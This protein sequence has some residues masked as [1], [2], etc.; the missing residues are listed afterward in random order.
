MKW[1]LG[2]GPDVDKAAR[3]KGR[4]AWRRV[5]HASLFGLLVVILCTG[6]L[7]F[8]FPPGGQVTLSVG[9]VSPTDIR[10]PAQRTFVSDILTQ[11]ARA[12]AEA[13]VQDVYDPPEQRVAR[14]QIA[15]ARD[16]L[17]FIESVRHDTAASDEERAAYLKAIAD[18]PL[19]D[20]VVSKILKLSDAAWQQ[21][22]DE[23]LRVLGLV[24]REEIRQTWLE[25]KR[26]T[27]PARVSL[28]LDEA[29]TDVVV[30]LVR[31]LMRSNTFYNAEKTA[32]LRRQKADSVEPVGRTIEVGEVILR[33][34]DI[35]DE[36]DVEALEALGLREDELNW[37]EVLE[38][39]AFLLV[40]TITGWLYLGRTY[41]QIW[42]S[43]LQAALV[44][45]LL[46]LFT[47]L[48]KV[49]VAGHVA[50][51]YLFPLA[52]LSMLLASL[53][54]LQVGVT[55]AVMLALVAGYLS[56]GSVEI[57][58]YLLVGG[59][60]APLSTRRVAR[61]NNFLWM[62]VYVGLAEA[63]TVLAFRLPSGNYDWLGLATLLSAA[64]ANGAFSSSVTLLAL[65]LLGSIFRITT[66]LRLMELAR[67]THPLLNQLLLK[68]PGTYNH[69]L[70]ISNLAEQ[71]AEAIGADSQL[72]RV[73]AYYHD[74]GKTLRPYFY[75]DNQFDGANVHERLDP[76]T[77]AQIV[78][79]HVTDGIELGKKHRL[80]ARVLAF[81]AEH[82]G[83]LLA[84]YFYN[85]ACEQAG[86][87]EHVDESLYRYPGPKPQ[88][89]ETAIVM[90]A[91]ACEAL[92]RSERPSTAEEVD[93]LVQRIIRKRIE[94][95]QLDECDLTMRD[96]EKIR[97]AFVGVLQGVYHPRI[98]YLE[99]LAPG[100]GGV[101]PKPAE[102]AEALHPA[103]REEVRHG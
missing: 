48:A 61:L 87:C 49:M 70:L 74:I 58:V 18:L 100:K 92:V 94:Q 60:V 67:P 20:T 43:P 56:H 59:L 17:D 65:F 96:L 69:T 37:Q 23:V 46:V 27:V 71:A 86:G 39:A 9:D 51:P 62:G 89:R 66:P 50:L 5:L 55:S 101:A 42:D 84:Q 80:P 97:R 99:P 24:M 11:Q 4:S 68:A 81:I 79:S 78:I 45:T 93:A 95:G 38:I 57:M 98:R 91:D 1:K 33:A 82:H 76:Q 8:R 32:E 36:L 102:P 47:A 15:R 14:Q 2:K 63:V 41:P 77:S 75:V 26:R 85:E 28:D 31:G 72:A 21:V 73:G 53:L 83:T 22:A 64:V 29:Q 6:A 13:L 103:V 90:L 12:A 16:I 54:H 30:A 44:A 25:E 3:R 7:A 35:V 52:G 34:G 40:I 10:S 19:D 88:S